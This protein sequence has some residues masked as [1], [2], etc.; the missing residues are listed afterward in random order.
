M[1]VSQ[2]KGISGI[3]NGLGMM[4]LL[5]GGIARPL[6]KEVLVRRVQMPQGLLQGHSGD[7]F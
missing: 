7:F 1:T 2:G 6:L 4:F 3:G 5:E